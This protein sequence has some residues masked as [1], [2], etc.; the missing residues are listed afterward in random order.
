MLTENA[1]LQKPQVPLNEIT[2]PSYAVDEQLAMCK[3]LAG[4]GP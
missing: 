1:R 3:K 2:P 4:H